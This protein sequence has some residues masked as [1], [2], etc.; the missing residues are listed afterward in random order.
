MKKTATEAIK[1]ETLYET[2]HKHSKKVKTINGTD[3][4]ALDIHA[5]CLDKLREQAKIQ[6]FLC[7]NW[8]NK[9]QNASEI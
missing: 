9:A 6:E 7:R 8:K 5:A 2:I 3:V 1:I 4:F